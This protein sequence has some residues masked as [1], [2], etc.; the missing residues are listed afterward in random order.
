MALIYASAV[1]KR[2]NSGGISGCGQKLKK[3]NSL[4][5]S[6]QPRFFEDIFDDR[7]RII[8]ASHS[9]QRSN[10]EKLL[11]NDDVS[12]NHKCQFR[13][14]SV[15]KDTQVTGEPANLLGHRRLRE[16]CSSSSSS[17]NCSRDSRE[18]S[19]CPNGMSHSVRVKRS[20][21]SGCDSK[22]S[23]VAS[24][25]GKS[26]LPEQTLCRKI[27][28]PIMFCYEDANDNIRNLH[29]ASLKS[30]FKT[31]YSPRRPQSTVH[32]NLSQDFAGIIPNKPIQKKL[33]KSNTEKRLFTL[34]SSPK[35]SRIRS[36]SY[37]SHDHPDINDVIVSD[38]Y[39]FI[40]KSETSAF[41]KIKN[42]FRKW[43]L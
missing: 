6:S 37:D 24:Y 21:T 14:T 26:S 40:E 31:E 5:S 11:L 18:N 43:K 33:P 10:E 38:S 34:D 1:N 9:R 25:S 8:A 27:S 3:K 42:K 19:K 29:N 2:I 7:N 15:N 36:S 30:V 32:K 28:H 17:R 35:D 23:V 39:I 16:S 20:K 41:Q 4:Q 13:S 12:T 22:H